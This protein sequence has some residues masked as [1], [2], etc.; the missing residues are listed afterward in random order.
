MG[1]TV[2]CNQCGA[3]LPQLWAARDEIVRLRDKLDSTLA[4]LEAERDAGVLL[5]DALDALN[6][7]EA[8]T[9]RA[10]SVLDRGHPMLAARDPHRKDAPP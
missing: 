7:Y 2:T 1:R 5:A 9:R 10:R 6:G 4:D 3:S 8:A